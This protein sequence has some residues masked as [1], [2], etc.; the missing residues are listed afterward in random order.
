[1]KRIQPIALALIDCSKKARFMEYNCGEV[2]LE[3]VNG[4]LMPLAKQE[5]NLIDIEKNAGAYGVIGA[6]MGGLMALY[7]GMRYP[8]IFGHVISQSGAFR[9]FISEEKLLYRHLID[10]FPTPPPLKIWMD[11]GVVEW[12]VE[13][14][15]DTSTLLKNK[16]WDVTYH[17]F[18]GG[19]NNRMW[20]NM[21]EHA[22][23][24]IFPYEEKQS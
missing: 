1:K 8:H 20:S 12:L 23:P 19:H 24:T 5:L 2:T 16:G 10:T 17:E 18:N 21:L 15:R 13:A 6:S 4:L 9:N 22:L 14:N 3:L 7:T 11:C